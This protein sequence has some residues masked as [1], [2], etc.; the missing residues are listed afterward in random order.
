MHY[1]EK[2]TSRADDAG[3]ISVSKSMHLPITLVIKDLRV[4]T[5]DCCQGRQHA[6]TCKLSGDGDI[7][8]IADGLSLMDCQPLELFI[9]K[10]FAGGMWQMDVLVTG[11][12]ANEVVQAELAVRFS[13]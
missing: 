1:T 6:I 8:S 2:F 9:E 13:L 7:V 3:V 5:L 12:A 11:F 4:T 10:R